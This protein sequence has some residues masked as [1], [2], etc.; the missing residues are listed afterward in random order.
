MCRM[1]KPPKNARRLPSVIAEQVAGL[2]CVPAEE[3]ELFCDGLCDSVAEVWRLD[4]RA[5]SLKPGRALTEAAAAARTLNEAVCSL[6]KADRKWV[7]RL[8]AS[9]PQLNNEKR[10]FGSAEP[11]QID[12][13]H[14][15][16]FLLAYLFNT[17]IGKSTPVLAGTATLPTKRG[18]KKVPTKPAFHNFVW[19]LLTNTDEAGGKKLSLDKNKNQK[20]GSL[21]RALDILRPYLPSNSKRPKSASRD[22]TKNKNTTIES[23]APFAREWP[24]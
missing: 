23:A 20:E 1:S 6:K 8:V 9:N 5:V 18:P 2:A 15:T 11:F 7:D 12:E 22:P 4:R 16:V 14:Q 21:V 3:Q 24:H 10:L 19:R 13:L 17:A